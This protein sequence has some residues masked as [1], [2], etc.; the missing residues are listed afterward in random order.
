M[1]QYLCLISFSFLLCLPSLWSQQE[2]QFTQFM[3]YRQGL[4]PGYVG[5]EENINIMAM[6]RNQ[7]LG[8][9]GA[10]QTQLISVTAPI[11]NQRIGVGGNI[12]RQTIGVTDFYT[13][14]GMYSYR[15]KVP[16]GFLGI[17]LQASI[18]LLQA[19]FTSLR[20]T[21]PIT[22]DE[23]IPQGIQSKFVPNFG[24]GVYYHSRNFYLGFSIPRL[25]TTNIDLSDD[26]GVI[27]KEVN[28]AY[29]MTGTTIKLGETLSL[30]PQ[31]LLK[32][33]PGAPFDAD[34][35][36]NLLI[37]EK[38]STGI[39]Y[40][41]GGSIERGIGEAASMLVGIQLSKSMFLGLSYDATL[42]ELRNYNSGTI[43]GL[44]IYRIGAK[45]KE[46]EVDNPRFF[47]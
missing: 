36:V 31:F 17:G 35:N 22:Q 20:G 45:D 7:W 30:Q 41:L 18:R 37:G 14:D 34:I 38:F 25:L 27:A 8:L 6:S 2:A 11:L 46:E 24:L 47:N 43:E 10:P 9:E 21:Q 23:A 44:V 42:S 3:H 39:S 29:M 33:V 12:L 28:H 16:R 40:R 5:S 19:D 32:Y 26:S 1:K 15:L 4:N 13:L